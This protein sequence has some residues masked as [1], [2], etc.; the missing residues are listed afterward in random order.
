MKEEL[1]GLEELEGIPCNSDDIAM[2][3]WV[4]LDYQKCTEMY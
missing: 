4:V 3:N 1:E 2:N